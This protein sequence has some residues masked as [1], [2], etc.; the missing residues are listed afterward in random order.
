VVPKRP[1][2][3]LLC[4][5]DFNRKSKKTYTKNGD[6]LNYSAS[7]KMGLF[8]AEKRNNSVIESKAQNNKKVIWV[9]ASWWKQNTAQQDVYQLERGEAGNQV[10]IRS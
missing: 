4:R 9:K 10:K 7:E 2:V 8:G 3:C 5:G 6:T 1:V